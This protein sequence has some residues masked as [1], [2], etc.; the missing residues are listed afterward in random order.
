[1]WVLFVN[2]KIDVVNDTMDDCSGDDLIDEKIQEMTNCQIYQNIWT[3]LYH[4]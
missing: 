4:V 1:M 3:V 2:A